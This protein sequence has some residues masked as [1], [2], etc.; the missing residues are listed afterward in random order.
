MES[1]LKFFIAIGGA[2]VSFLFGGWVQLMT[3]LIV[4]IVIVFMSS[5]IFAGKTGKH[6]AVA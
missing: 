4:F 5:L 1:L 2:V 6:L 3:I